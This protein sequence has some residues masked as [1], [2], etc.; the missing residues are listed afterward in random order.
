MITTEKIE[1]L[2]TE[3]QQCNRGYGF[4]DQLAHNACRGI[5]QTFSV[6]LTLLFAATVFLEISRPAH[7]VLCFIL[8]FIGIL[9]MFTLLLDLES[10]ASC[11]VAL[12]KRCLEIE[13]EIASPDMFKMWDVIER[14]NKF[15]EEELFKGDP[16]NA[17]SRKKDRPEPEY[18]LFVIAARVIICLWVLLVLSVMWWGPSIRLAGQ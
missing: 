17:N 12:R 13:G 14:R 11:K 7:I 4:R 8:L 3:Y 10:T 16:T 9:A 6:F 18:G 5:I 2:I 1:L 15:W